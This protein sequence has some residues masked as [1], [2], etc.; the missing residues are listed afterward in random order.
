QVIFQ[1][2]MDGA[3]HVPHINP[4]QPLLPISNSPAEAELK[5][6]KHGSQGAAFWTQHNSS[7]NMRGA[8]VRLH[9]RRRRFFPFLANLR[10]KS[11]ARGTFLAPRFLASIG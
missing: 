4:A 6:Q 5:R 8:D 1:D 9:R 2:V 3:D 10:Q 11:R 7:S